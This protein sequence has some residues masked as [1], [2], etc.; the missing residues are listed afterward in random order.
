MKILLITCVF[1]IY[2]LISERLLRKKLNI[3]KSTWSIYVPVNT[4][5]KW[6]ERIIIIGFLISIW[7]VENTLPLTL[8][9]FTIFNSMR[10][11]MEWKYE[12]EKREYLLT[13]FSSINLVVFLLTLMIFI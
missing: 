12:R 3:N 4:V 9:F 6:S 5:H 2:G 13:L 10:A 7:F 1:V 8:T 11:F